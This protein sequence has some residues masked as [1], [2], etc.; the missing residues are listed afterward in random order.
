MN[1]KYWIGVVSEQHVL[2]G[3]DG[4]FAQLCHPAHENER[5]RLADLLFPERR[6]S[7]RQTAAK[8]YRDR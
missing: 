6:I 5:G 2:K 3:A 7:R 8:L 1:T 4:G